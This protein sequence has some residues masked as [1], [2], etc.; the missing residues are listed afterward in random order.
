MNLRE[1]QKKLKIGIINYNLESQWHSSEIINRWRKK[2]IKYFPQ[3]LY[4]PQNLEHQVLFRLT[5]FDPK[6]INEEII[7]MVVEEQYLIIQSALEK[8][9]CDL[10]YLFRGLSGKYKDLNIKDRLTLHKDN[11]NDKLLAI[12]ENRSFEVEFKE[13]DDEKIIN[14]FTQE[15]HYIHNLRAK[16]QTFGLFFKGD[17][18]PFAIETT[19]SSI[20]AKEYKR[21]ALLAH[22]ID[23]NKAVE[24]T[25]LY[26]L[27]GSP[28]NS[29]SLMDGLIS[30]Y[31]QDKGVEALFTTTMPMYAKSKATTISGGI[32]KVLLVKDLRHTFIE[33]RIK[34]KTVYRHVI[35]LSEDL[36]GSKIITTHPNFPK[37]LVVEVYKILNK[38]TLE[39]LDILRD[40]NKVIYVPLE[41]RDPKKEIEIKFKINCL[42]EL[43]AQLNKNCCFVK[44]LYIRDIIYGTGI[45]PAEK[46]FRLRIENSMENINYEVVS[47]YK[48]QEHGK[49]VASIEEIFYK[50]DNKENAIST[51][52]KFG[53]YNEENSYEKIRLVY[54]NNGLEFDVDIYPYGVILEIEGDIETSKEFINKLGFNL[55]EAAKENADELFLKWAQKW[56]LPEFW[57][58]RFGLTGKK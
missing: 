41:R 13:V 8:T 55:N 22:G 31:Y 50:G 14:L 4:D 51:I 25:R 21:E 44:T 56:K 15:F 49:F 1:K 53:N 18:I 27:P 26:C 10:E 58:I 5:T 35:K 40:K 36:K 3:G 20:L 54:E 34:D 29:I 19:E 7:K 11:K 38:P 52:K 32:N 16:G 47:K 43:L 12:N 39:E 42:D 37:M 9:N 46:K 6:E 57:E 30:K 2:I 48:I 17:K 45:G 33:E 28:K 24:L 23:P